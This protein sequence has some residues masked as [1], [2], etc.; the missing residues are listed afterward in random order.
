MILSDFDL[1]SY[2]RSGR[3][4]IEPFSEEIIRENG[5][6]LRLGNQIARLRDT[7]EVL[8]TRNPEADLSS[9][10]VIEEGETFII[11]PREKVLLTS[12]EYIKLPND[13]MAFVELR[14]SFA[15]LGLLMPPTIIDAGFEGTVT[16]EI[17]G[18]SFP[19]KLYRGQRFA[20][21]I[22]SKTLNPVSKPYKGKYQGQQGVTLPKL[23]GM[24]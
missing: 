6:D 20:H 13:L 11:N 10:Y 19:I 22:F 4:V 5:I 17:Q 24:K 8:D 9:F 7:D 16:L 15:R 2:I 1:T 12:L 21:V 23:S 3:L 18:S 14:S